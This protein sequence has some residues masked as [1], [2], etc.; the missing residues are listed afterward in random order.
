MKRIKWADENGLIWASLI[1]DSDPD[2]VA[3][4][5]ILCGPPDINDL[6]WNAIKRDLHTHL[7]DNNLLTWADVQVSQ[8]G[9]QRAILAVL[10]KRLIALYRAKEVLPND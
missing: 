10:R 4:D 1:R 2:R 3:P 7:I 9:I 5:G 6:D 8:N